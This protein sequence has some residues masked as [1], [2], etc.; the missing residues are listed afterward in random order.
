MIQT[1]AVPVTADMQLR[2]ATSDTDVPLDVASQNIT[3]Q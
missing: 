2:I 1:S 3:A